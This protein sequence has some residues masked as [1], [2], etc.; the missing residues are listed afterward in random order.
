[1]THIGVF[2]QETHRA[3]NPTYHF[4]QTE[5]RGKEEKSD[6]NS[7]ALLISIRYYTKCTKWSEYK[8]IHTESTIGSSSSHFS[9]W[10]PAMKC[11][12]LKAQLQGWWHVLKEWFYNTKWWNCTTQLKIVFFFPCYFPTSTATWNLNHLKGLPLEPENKQ[13]HCPEGNSPFLVWQK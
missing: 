13:A 8:W 2:L 12:F 1:M 11:W 10:I 3:K 6:K 9:N 4:M 7:T 5:V